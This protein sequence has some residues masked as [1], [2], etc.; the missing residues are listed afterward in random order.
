[1][2]VSCVNY[3]VHFRHPKTVFVEQGHEVNFGIREAEKMQ[4]TLNLIVQVCDRASSS[5]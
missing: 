2:T 1:M 4:I 3:S 5:E